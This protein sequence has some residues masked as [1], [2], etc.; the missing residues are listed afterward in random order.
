MIEFR[1][2][3]FA[4]CATLALTLPVRAETPGDTLV[5]ADA[6]D[7]IVSLDPAESFEFSGEDALQ[8]VYDRLV[9]IVPA[10]NFQLEPGLAE[11]W[12]ASPDGKTFTF[13]LKDGLKFQSGNPITADDAAW[14]LQRAVKLNKTPAFILTQFGFTADNVDQLIKAT[15]PLELQ[16][17]TDK[18]YAQSFFYNILTSIVGSVVDKKEVMTHEANGDF[19]YEWLKTHAAG[20]GPYG[21]RSW[22]PNDSIILEA[23]GGKY[24]GGDVALKRVFIRHVP[25]GATRRLLLE[26]G[27]IDIARRLTPGDVEAIS[28][29][30]DLKVQNDQKGRIFY[31]AG[32]QKVEA[33]AKPQVREALKYLIDYDGMANSF[34]KGQMVVHQGFLPEGFL[35][36]ITDKP[37]KFDVA[38]AKSLLAEAGYPDGFS[39]TMAVR[40]DP[41]RV[42][43]AQAIQN[44]LA[45]AGIKVEINATTGAEELN[46]YRARQHQ[47]ILESWG[48]DY[49][50]PQTNASTFAAN[51]DNADTAKNAGYLAWRTAYDAKDTNAMVDAAVVEQDTTKR[52]AMYEDMQRL[53]QK[54]SPFTWLFQETEQIGERK[55]VNGFSSGGAV[56]SAFYWTVTK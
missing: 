56:S 29:N 34:L 47:L 49:P 21:L 1:S 48:P 46:A 5:I 13:K 15:G 3:A 51:P 50:D 4:A 16:I 11:S 28:A 22:K 7:D 25:E 31:L 24:W 37:Y 36:A 6:I 42:D 26:K 55:N 35:G 32:N 9:Q 33:L 20:S 27:D 41:I 18:A 38:K 19:G 17:T 43:M 53:A 30:G 54:V 52:K 2:L 40:N 8:N 23:A 10:H 45:Q 14:S 39:V 44:T 12:S